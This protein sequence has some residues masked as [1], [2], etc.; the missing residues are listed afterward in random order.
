MDMSNIVERRWNIVKILKRILIGIVIGIAI[1]ILVG[2]LFSM[3]DLFSLLFGGQK[4]PEIQKAE[5]PFI[6]EYVMDGETYI[7]EDIVV[8][9][10]DGFDGMLPNHR[11]WSSYLKSGN[12]T[13]CEL[14]R[15]ENS[16]SVLKS[17]RVNELSRLVLDYGSAEY[18]MDDPQGNS[19]IDKEATFEYRENWKVSEKVTDVEHTKLNAKQLRKYFN[20]EIIRFEFSKPIKN[21]FK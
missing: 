1:I 20:I 7:I 5:F 10:F 3:I 2:R 6:V 18:Y 9:E 19:M 13:K 8:C 21:K 11:C 14:I 12:E 17:S 4:Y 15:E 16:K